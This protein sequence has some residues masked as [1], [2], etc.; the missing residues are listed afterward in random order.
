MSSDK[1]FTFCNYV[2]LSIC[3]LVVLIPLINIVSQSISHPADVYAGKVILWPTRL[4]MAGYRRIWNNDDIISGFG[5]SIIITFSGTLISLFLTVI[6][7]YPLSRKDLLGRGAIMWLFT[8]TM[9]FNAG[10]IPTYLQI[11][12]LGLIDT[13]WSLILINALSAWNVIIARTFFMHTIPEELYD[14][15]N[16]DGCSDISTMMRIVLPLSKPILAILVLFYAVGIWNSYFDAM[17]F[18]QTQGKYP[19]QLVLRNIMTSAQLQA[20]IMG[21]AAGADHGLR[22]AETDVM[23]YAVIVFSSLPLLLLYPFIQRHFVKGL[24]IGA[25]KG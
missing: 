24:M 6:A 1:V 21:A 14:A 23:K 11:Q 10:L 15:A 4:S 3:L 13:R 5:N 19:L 25:V 16:I 9:L 2:F 7:A 12:S 18:L 20:N 22:L 17:I 8:F